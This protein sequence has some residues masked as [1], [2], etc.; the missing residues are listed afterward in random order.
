MPAPCR[1]RHTATTRR[2]SSSSSRADRRAP[3]TRTGRS[4]RARALTRARQNTVS[5]PQTPRRCP[6]RQTDRKSGFSLLVELAHQRVEPAPCPS[7]PVSLD[8]LGEE[9]CAHGVKFRSAWC[10]GSGTA[11]CRLMSECSGL[12][13]GKSLVSRSSGWG[14]APLGLRGG[15]RSAGPRARPFAVQ[16]GLRHAKT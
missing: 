4:A 6:H 12:R 8:G 11:I 3:A 16:Q 14:G 2:S 5:I 1:R 13:V 7:P 9:T 10:S 15:A